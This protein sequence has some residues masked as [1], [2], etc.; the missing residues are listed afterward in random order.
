MRPTGDLLRQ[1]MEEAA[2]ALG[3]LTRFP[4]P[5]FEMRSMASHA[6]AFWAY[7]VAGALIGAVGALAFWLAATMGFSTG[8]CAVT[9]LAATILASGGLHEDGLADFWDGLGG[10]DT[11]EDKLEIMQDS[12][13]GT[14]GV[15]AL[16]LT[17]GAQGLLLVN[18]H[19][20]AGLATAMAGLIA[21]E[22]AAR[23]AIGVPL[24]TMLPART[25]GMGQSMAELQGPTLAAGMVI[26]AILALL[27]LGTSGFAVILGAAIGAAFV[28][29]LAGVFLG[30]FTGDVLGA[31][32]AMARA[33]ALGAL[34]LMVTP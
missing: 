29:M 14:Y 18:L 19:H 10:G 2:L 21:S 27:L 31:S 22:A 12:R 25:E 32:A 20:Y 7:P 24:G 34:V 15:L 1:W 6:S 13:I 16:M 23:G 5:V 11:R 28:S 30:G 17:V 33:G 3:L 26:A 4:L 9:A 8:V